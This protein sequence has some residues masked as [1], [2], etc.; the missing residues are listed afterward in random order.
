MATQGSR[1]AESLAG[2]NRIL[3]LAAI[4]LGLLA[5]GGERSE[6][7]DYC[8]KSTGAINVTYVG[9]AFQVPAKG[10]C[11]VWT[12]FCVAGCSPD[13]A[14]TGSACTASNGSRVTFVLTTAYLADNRQW[15][16]IRLDLPAQTGSGNSNN[17]S[18]GVGATV[19]YS[20]K[21]STCTIPV[22]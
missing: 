14:Q 2:A 10:T 20:A 17:F 3:W 11:R 6:A 21:G 9:K 19:P 12:G 7:A 22:P 4:V 16:F 15:D 8:I 18:G 13:N 5:A 1:P